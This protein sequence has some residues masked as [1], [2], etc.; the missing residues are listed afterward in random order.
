VSDKLR[1][2]EGDSFA[3]VS[4]VF[5]EM[6]KKREELSHPKEHGWW[7]DENTKHLVFQLGKEKSY[8]IGIERLEEGAP[9]LLNFIFRLLHRAF[10]NAT[11]MYEFLEAVDVLL[12]PLYNPIYTGRYK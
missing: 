12:D 10:I 4:K 11:D 8:D 6:Q 5:E 1:K 9:E 2:Y 7:Y 3:K